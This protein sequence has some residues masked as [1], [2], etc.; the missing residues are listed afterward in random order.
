MSDTPSSSPLPPA[1]R[2]LCRFAAASARSAPSS[3]ALVAAV[4][5]LAGAMISLPFWPEQARSLWRGQAAIPPAPTPGIDLPTVQAAADTVAKAAVEAA[6]RDLTV[7]LDDLEKRLRAVSADR[8]PNAPSR[9]SD[10]QRWPSCAARSS[11]SGSRAARAAPKARADARRP[12]P[13]ADPGRAVQHRCRKEIATLHREIATLQTALLALNQAVDGQKDET[14]KQREQAKALADAVGARGTADQKALVAARAS[15]VI[16]VAARLSAALESGLPF[17]TD[18]ALLTPLVQGDAKLGRNRQRAAALRLRPASPRAQHSPP[19]SP[20]SPKRPWP[21]TLPMIRSGQRLLGKI[22]ASSRCAGSATTLRAIR[23]KPSWRAP[24]PP[25]RPA[26]LA[27]AVDLVK[28]MPP[29]TNK[30]TAAWLARAEAHLAA[31]RAVDQLAAPCRLPA[32][33]GAL[34]R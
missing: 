5:V 13:S 15:A 2:R 30:A 23:S 7:R 19:S 10:P 34:I 14:A 1:H 32:G 21:T 25:S 31:K 8:R 16:G 22:R 17:A 33:R 6:Q 4:I 3:S 27:K 20:P 24:R 9:G 26:D 29:Q 11:A 28:S 12:G 18:L